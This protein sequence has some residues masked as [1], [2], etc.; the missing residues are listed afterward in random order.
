MV[1]CACESEKKST[2]KQ[3]RRQLTLK[4]WSAGDQ[5]KYFILSIGP[6]NEMGDHIR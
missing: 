4:Y 2:D 5:P 3:K 6:R 1:K